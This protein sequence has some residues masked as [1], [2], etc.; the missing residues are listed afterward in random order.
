MV[1]LKLLNQSFTDLYRLATSCTI[2]KQKVLIWSLRKVNMYVYTYKAST[3]RNFKLI[4]W[5]TRPLHASVN[6][7]RL[8]EN[9]NYWVRFQR[10]STIRIKAYVIYAWEI[11]DYCAFPLRDHVQISPFNTNVRSVRSLMTPSPLSHFIAC[12]RK[13]F[14]V[15]VVYCTQ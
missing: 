11:G 5:Q 4:H 10:Y 12:S 7:R 14:I 8:Q 1:A 6:S 9:A 2:I 3:L 15:I 13:W